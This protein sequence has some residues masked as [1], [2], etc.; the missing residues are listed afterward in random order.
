MG[1]AD[2]GE[3]HPQGDAA[4]RRTFTAEC[5]R[6]GAPL[7]VTRFQ[8]EAV[9]DHC[10]ATVFVDEAAVPRARFARALRAWDEGATRA[11]G[12]ERCV[13]IAD[14]PWA[15][16][17][18]IGVGRRCEVWAATLARD[19]TER[20]VVKVLAA[21]A[22]AVAAQRLQHEQRVLEALVA[23]EAPGAHH[24]ARRLPAVVGAGVV[25]GA[26]SPLE[27]RSA[28]VLRWCAGFVHTLVDVREHYPGGVLAEHVA[29]MWRR[30]L[31]S[32]AFAHAAG[33]AHGALEAAH[34]L[35]HAKDHGVLPVAWGAAA[36]ATPE[37]RAA[38]ARAAALAVAQVMDGAEVPAAM[39]ALVTEVVRHPAEHADAWALRE[40]VGEVA[41]ACFGPPRF[42]PFPMPGW[43]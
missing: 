1:S 2:D 33:W 31:E 15:I 8:R 9:C 17:R 14:R 41:R 7:T 18:R 12:A 40:R 28:L 5:S 10:G 16:G 38:D 43:G 26:A 35:V 30:V 34:L 39:A 4:P 6:C 20:V 11:H 25:A 23:S 19:P 24:H 13:W 37:A 27:G 36:P 22:D 29:W 3:Q 21:G 32:L 42:V